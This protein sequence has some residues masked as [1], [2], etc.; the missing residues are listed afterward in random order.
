[1]T[2]FQRP[3][4]PR[5]AR[6][7]EQLPPGA[8]PPSDAQRA[9]G[10][11]MAQTM[12]SDNP[13]T[14]LVERQPYDFRDEQP[15]PPRAAP[16]TNWAAE[17]AQIEDVEP[18]LDIHTAEVSA[19]A[20]SEVLVSPEAMGAGAVGEEALLAKTAIPAKDIVR[21]VEHFATGITGSAHPLTVSGVGSLSAAPEGVDT[22]VNHL[23]KMLDAQLMGLAVGGETLQWAIDEIARLMSGGL[24]LE[25]N[26]DMGEAP[27]D[28]TPFIGMARY[29]ER[30]AGFPRMVAFVDGAWREPGRTIGEPLVCWAWISRDVLPEWPAEP[31]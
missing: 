14:S 9:A 12:L 8:R 16:A 19:E 1:M 2:T 3:G 30:R 7:P 22:P 5:R 27:D 6:K 10:L 4:G 23:K 13:E 25:W 11:A 21:A 29:A 26:Y 20:H 17:A 18:V 28:G 24:V 15:E 31:A